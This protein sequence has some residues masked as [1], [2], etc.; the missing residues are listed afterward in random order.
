MLTLSA[1]AL[2]LT[3]SRASWLAAMLGTLPFVVMAAYFRVTRNSSARS[4]MALS[5][6]LAGVILSVILP[7]QLRWSSSHPYRESAKALMTYNRGS[8]RFRLT[9]DHRS[10]VMAADHFALGVGPGNWRIVYPGYLP[11]KGPPRL[12]YPRMASNEWI[13]LAAERG[14]PA[15]IL[16][17]AA[18]VSLG[19]GCWRSFIRLRCT[20]SC[21]ERSLE[22]LCAIAILAALA[23]VGSLDPVLQ[24]GASSFVFFLAIGALAPRQEIIASRCLSPGR[25]WLG[26]ATAMLLAATLSLVMADRMYAIS[27][28]ARNRGDDLEMATRIAID[29]DWFYNER[30]WYWFRAEMWRERQGHPS[31][32]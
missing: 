6:L 16:F 9:Q 21:P 5:A 4:C 1:A 19:V 22:L 3:R 7:T 32:R 14:V 13:T 23:V 29:R 12:W 26:I 17:L 8:G 15:A 27:L 11:R 24:L 30:L 10:L 18:L 31:A 20:G 28:M 2:V 25:R